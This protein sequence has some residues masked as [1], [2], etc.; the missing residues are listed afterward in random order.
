MHETTGTIYAVIMIDTTLY[1]LHKR[2]PHNVILVL[3]T[4]NY[5]ACDHRMI[6][7]RQP[8]FLYHG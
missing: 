4:V 6:S 7:V 5:I 3:Y 2:N 8:P 1:Q